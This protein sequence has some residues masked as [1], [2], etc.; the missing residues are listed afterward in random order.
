[1]FARFRSA[2]ARGQGT[3]DAGVRVASQQR[4]LPRARSWAG[5]IRSGWWPRNP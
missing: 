5:K 1:L 3:S 2:F 4:R